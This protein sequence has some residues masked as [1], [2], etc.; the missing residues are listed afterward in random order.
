MYTFTFTSCKKENTSPSTSQIETDYNNYSLTG[1]AALAKITKLQTEFKDQN[2]KTRDGVDIPLAEAVWNIE[3]TVN[4]NYAHGN[5]RHKKLKVFKDTVLI[6]TSSVAGLKVVSPTI[7]AQKYSQVVDLVMSKGNSFNYPAQNRSLIFA[8]LNIVNSSPVTTRLEIIIGI[9][10]D[11]KDC[12]TCPIAIEPDIKDCKVTDDWFFGFF[13][14]KCVGP[15]Q[16]A[17]QKGTD[18]AKII[19]DFINNTT[20]AGYKCLSLLDPNPNP[21]D[22][23]PINPKYHDFIKPSDYPMPNNSTLQDPYK[24]RLYHDPHHLINTD[25]TCLTPNDIDHFRYQAEYIIGYEQSINYNGLWSNNRKFVDCWISGEAW[26][27]QWDPSFEHQMG[28]RT[29]DYI[30]R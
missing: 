5:F 23:Y 19:Q 6:N 15:G 28:Y 17:V 7:Q 2:S 24:Y 16:P 30:P 26:G 21:N 9:G 4:A 13:K 1:D 3:S 18:A 11:P 27:F 12:P 25:L 22:W 8:D 10:L 20:N 29:A 14:G